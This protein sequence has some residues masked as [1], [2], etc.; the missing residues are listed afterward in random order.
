MDVEQWRINVA[1]SL[2]KINSQLKENRI[3]MGNLH[4]KV[5]CINNKLTGN[6][7]TGLLTR[8]EVIEVQCKQCKDVK[9]SK[10]MWYYATT[11]AMLAVIVREAWCWLIERR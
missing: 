2:G 7:K 8:V 9:K 1:E 10:I 11:T 4:E 6:G 5:T 3:Y